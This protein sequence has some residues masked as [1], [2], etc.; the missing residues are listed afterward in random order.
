MQAGHL[1]APGREGKNEKTW[2]IFAYFRLWTL[3]HVQKSQNGSIKWKI[4]QEF[5]PLKIKSIYIIISLNFY[6]KVVEIA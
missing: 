2:C 6:F 5:A 1:T 3:V 4:I